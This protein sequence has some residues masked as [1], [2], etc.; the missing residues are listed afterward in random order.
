MLEFQN[1]TKLYRGADCQMEVAPGLAGVSF[2]V[3]DGEFLSIVGRSG[4]G[5][6]T[7]LKLAV[8]LLPADSGAILLDGQEVAP[9]SSD[10]ALVFQEATLLPWRSV[11][12]NVELGLEAT[13]RSP[14]E[15][16]GLAMESLAMVGL[17]AFANS[18]PYNLSGGMQQRVGVARALAVRP[19]VLLMDEPFAAVDDFTRESLRRQLLELWGEL[20]M[21]VLFVTHDIDEAIFLGNRICV[22]GSAPGHV[23]DILDVPFSYPR[24]D[25]GIRES[26]AGIELR[27]RVVRALHSSDHTVAMDRGIKV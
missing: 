5:K 13:S 22:L 27:A 6:S 2:T 7:L 1:V 4:C 19:R 24:D 10:V 17:E 20:R 8:R 12:G 16:R 26:R 25:S 15:R 21:S 18:P 3:D 9:G 14:R 11:L 23:V